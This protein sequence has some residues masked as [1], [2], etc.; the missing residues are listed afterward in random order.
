[1][2]KELSPNFGSH[3]SMTFNLYYDYQHTGLTI[4]LYDSI[5]SFHTES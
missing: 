5:Y 3:S 1:M 2:D 4:L